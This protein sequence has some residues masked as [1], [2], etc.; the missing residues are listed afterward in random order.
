M[1]WDTDIDVQVSER[2]MYLLA[3]YY[4]MTEYRFK[5][6][7]IRGSRTYL[8]EVNPHFVVRTSDDFLNVIDARWIDTY[9]GLFID[10]TAV[11]EDYGERKKGHE[12]ALT[13]KDRHRYLVRPRPEPGGQI[14]ER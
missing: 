10:I 2:T 5:L 12:G 11:S 8:L 9:S 1:P 7:G 13:C 6:P 4:N 3:R 14:G